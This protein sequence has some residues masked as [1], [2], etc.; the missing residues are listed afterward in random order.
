ME[1]MVASQGFSKDDMIHF[2]HCR[3]AFRAMTAA[4][5]LTGNGIKVTKNAIDLQRLSRPSSTWDWPN[6]SPS[7]KDIS[8]WK[9]GLKRVTSANF[10][11]PFSLRLECW[12]NPSHLRWQ[13]FYWRCEHHLYHHTNGVW[14]LYVP[15]SACSSVAFKRVGIVAS[16]PIPIDD[17]ERATIWY[18]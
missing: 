16:P 3:L 2:N 1:H 12:I 18:D 15:F 13:W 7:N 5:I 14:H 9:S 17:L 8:C 6:E 10:S 11:L 4:D